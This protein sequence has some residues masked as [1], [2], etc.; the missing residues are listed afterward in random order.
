[1]RRRWEETVFLFYHVPTG[2][3]SLPSFP[4]HYLT[5]WC[6]SHRESEM[7]FLIVAFL[8]STSVQPLLGEWLLIGVMKGVFRVGGGASDCFRGGSEN[9]GEYDVKA[10]F[11]PSR[12]L[13]SRYQKINTCS[14]WSLAG[15]LSDQ[16]SATWPHRHAGVELKVALQCNGYPGV[17]HIF[18]HTPSVRLL[19]TLWNL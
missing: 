19:K 5:V 11:Q 14:N 16:V 7:Y 4:W 12:L 3:P 13:F 8:A 18:I 10:R 6:K 15:C 9:Q 17:F 1:M 2:C